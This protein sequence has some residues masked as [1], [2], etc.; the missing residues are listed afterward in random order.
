MDIA[1][2]MGVGEK[3]LRNRVKLITGV[4]L[5]EYLRNFRLEKARQLIQEGYST[6]GEIA[7]A[8][9]HSSL[10]YFS[11]RYKLYFGE[12]PSQVTQ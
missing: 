12:S 9:G 10:S 3:T 11:K 6:L 5:K 8:T 2:A 7:S 1:Q 4:T